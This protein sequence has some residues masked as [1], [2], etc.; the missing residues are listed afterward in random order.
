[1]G[2][3][4]YIHGVM[5]VGELMCVSEVGKKGESE[6]GRKE[7]REGGRREEGR[8]KELVRT[9]RLQD[10]EGKEGNETAQDRILLFFLETS[11]SSRKANW[12]CF[13]NL[14]DSLWS[15]SICQLL[16]PRITS[17]HLGMFS[18]RLGLK[19]RVVRVASWISLAP[20]WV[21]DCSA[22]DYQGHPQSQAH[23]C[24]CPT[25]STAAASC[26]LPSSGPS[27]SPRPAAHCHQGC[28]HK[29]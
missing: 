19:R 25:I 21:R 22:P 17:Q 15:Q 10:G 11:A 5:A 3:Y 14:R 13:R 20:P 28:I 29:M 23:F 6:G 12:N 1:M 27:C 7:E 2:V 18:R 4:V 9:I 8:E 24:L 26:C 16:C